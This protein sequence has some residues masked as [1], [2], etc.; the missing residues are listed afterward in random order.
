MVLNS[1]PT[2][3]WLTG[4]ANESD[5]VLS[6]RSRYMRN[7]HG[8]RF[9]HAATDPELQEVAETVLSAAKATGEG[10]ESF[11]QM[12]TAERLY[13]VGTRLMS[14]DFDSG[15]TGRLLLLNSTRSV[16]IMVNEEDHLRVQALTPGLSVWQA[17]GMALDT[18]TSLGR[19]LS[20][21]HSDRLGF[22][23]ASPF[24]TGSGK[25]LSVLLH[26]IGLA[27]AKKLPAV[28]QMLV[29]A[30]VS[31]RGLFGESSR[32]IGAFV[33]VSFVRGSSDAFN[34]AIEYLLAAERKARQEFGSEAM[35]KQALIA[36][37]FAETS[38]A[39][40]LADS[41]RILAWARW[42]SAVGIDGWQQDVRSVDRLLS[43]L[44]LKAS[45]NETKMAQHRAR[46]LRQVLPKS[47]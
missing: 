18:L 27:H 28:L 34:G 11:R 35:A 7:L 5:V 45:G 22:L 10:W 31:A 43:E 38:P 19:R 25:R 1:S 14:P 4:V 39:L 17:E 20:W 40:T 47:S 30:G 16:S 41:L 9:P 33:Q 21:A 12:S 32:A 46:V 44:E 3:A 6:S 29:D 8:I 2:P 36:S 26:L 13:M 15:Q 23:A 37:Q 42:A 24:N